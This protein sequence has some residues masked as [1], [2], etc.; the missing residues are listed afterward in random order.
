MTLERRHLSLDVVR[1]LPLFAGMPSALLR[2]LAEEMTL[3]TIKKR[4]VVFLPGDPGKSLFFVVDGRVKVSKVNR[5]GKELTLYYCQPG[6][7]LGEQILVE[8][9]PRQEMAEAFE[10]STLVEVPIGR[11]NQLIDQEVNFAAR[12][13]RALAHRQRAIEG[14]IE[15]LAFKDVH[16]KMAELLL[17]L[18]EE[19]GVIE[20]G[21]LLI[22]MKITHQ[23]MANLVG[24]T[25]ETVSLTLAQ[26]RKKGLIRIQGRKIVVLDKEG[27]KALS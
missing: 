21:G 19:E 20:T 8:G 2:E 1:G 12:L 18:A 15:Q 6:D 25:R 9:G 13:V 11:F 26:F 4:Q 5:D 7:F 24:S 10:A 3:H 27:L 16:A 23:E 22:A 14:R 17:R